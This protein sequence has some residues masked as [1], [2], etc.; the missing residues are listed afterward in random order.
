[1][2][3]PTAEGSHSEASVPSHMLHGWSG[4]SVRNNKDVPCLARSVELGS[5]KM[6]WR[7]L[8]GRGDSTAWHCSLHCLRNRHDKHKDGLWTASNCMR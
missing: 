2:R 8:L 4:Q 6:P 1:M 5:S 3:E 7:Y